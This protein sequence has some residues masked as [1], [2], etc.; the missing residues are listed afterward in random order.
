MIISIEGNIGSGKSTF[1][2]YIKNHFSKNHNKIQGKNIYFVVEP[3]KDWMSIKSS[4]G[5]LLECFYKKISSFS[6]E[7][8]F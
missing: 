8:K 4:E 2:N 1:C 3:V 5:N 6:V 7:N